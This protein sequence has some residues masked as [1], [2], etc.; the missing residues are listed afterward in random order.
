[1]KSMN[2]FQI[3]PLLLVLACGSE[4]KPVI[5]NPVPVLPYLEAIT[6]NEQLKPFYYGV[7]SGDPTTDAVVIWTHVTPENNEEQ[8]Q[9][10]WEMAKDSLFEKKVVTGKTF[11]LESSGFTVKVDVQGLEAG[12]IYYYRFTSAGVHS[13]T[14]R[15]KTLPL[16][17]EQIQLAFMSCSN[18]E[19][20][21]FNAYAHLALPKFDSLNA[22]VHL[23]DYIYEYGAGVYG[24]TTLGRNHLPDHELISLEDYRTRYAQYRSDPDLQAMHRLHPFI[25]T[26]DDHESA[27][28]SYKEGAQN[29]QE[30]EE[31][32]WADRKNA[33]KKAFFEWLPVRDNPGK[34]VYR[35]FRFGK[36]ANLIMLDTRLEGRSEQPSSME[37]SSRWDTTRTI[38]GNKQK[39]WFCEQLSDTTSIWKIVGNQVLFGYLRSDVLGY[40]ELYMDGWDGYAYEKQ[41]LMNY[42]LNNS[43]K[44]M[45]MV[46]GDYH[47]SFAQNL[48]FDV[49]KNP[50][51][52]P[53]ESVGVEFLVPSISSP[54]IDE[55][56]PLDTVKAIEKR[57]FYKNPQLKYVNLRDHGLVLLTIQP[58]FTEALFIQMNYR[59]KRDTGAHTDAVFTVKRNSSW[60]ISAN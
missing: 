20:G 7:A 32:T 6:T 51:D 17:P 42:I 50:N 31:G 38:L 18:Y 26:W 56:M 8:L 15:T 2:I 21:Y 25:G 9:L 27:N 14:G 46:T 54:N 57:F 34:S 58:E 39:N 3:V 53:N 45:V 43:I 33:A 13:P 49:F 28:N 12:N 35:N 48:Q 40:S 37:D 29:H 10:S 59:D 1:M 4:Q 16:D 30:G 5:E 11:A 60:L 36:L 24:D 44:N 23:G 55:R 19:G 22:V 47:S 41:Y 52:H